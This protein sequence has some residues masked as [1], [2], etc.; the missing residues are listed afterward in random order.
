MG[1]SGPTVSELR[2]LGERAKLNLINLFDV[3]YADGLYRGFT[4]AG[5]GRGAQLTVSALF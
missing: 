3:V 2:S 4:V 5:P 1:P